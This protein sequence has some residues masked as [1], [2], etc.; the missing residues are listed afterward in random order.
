MATISF[1]QL[2]YA[3][4]ENDDYAR[5]EL[6]RSGDVSSEVVVLIGSNPYKGSA[7]G[8]EFCCHVMICTYV[9]MYSEIIEYSLQLLQQEGTMF[10]SLKL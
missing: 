4:I 3:A 6:V 10:P 1:S 5:V 7:M 9:F 2:E 8:N